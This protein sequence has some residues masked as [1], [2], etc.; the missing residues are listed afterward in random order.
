MNN[1]AS[2]QVDLSPHAKRRLLDRFPVMQNYGIK[3]MLRELNNR[4][5]SG[6]VSKRNYN[7]VESKMLSVSSLSGDLPIVRHKNIDGAYFAIS[8]FPSWFR[9]DYSNVRKDVEISWI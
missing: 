5:H 7:H 9:A 4:H 3:A 2:I 1:Y 8:Y 6:V